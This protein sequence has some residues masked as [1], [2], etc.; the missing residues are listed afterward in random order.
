MRIP[1][2]HVES[3]RSVADVVFKG[4]GALT[5]TG[6]FTKVNDGTNQDLKNIRDAILKTKNY[7]VELVYTPN[8]HVATWRGFWGWVGGLKLILPT[9]GYEM[10]SDEIEWP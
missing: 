8:G 1:L 6:I 10:V 9:I 2:K 3:G 7:H 5:A 4:G